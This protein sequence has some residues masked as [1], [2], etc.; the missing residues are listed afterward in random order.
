ML[1]A[2]FPPEF[3]AVIFSLFPIILPVKFDPPA[4]MV[5]EGIFKFRATVYCP[6]PPKVPGRTAEIKVP[7]GIFVPE[8]ICPNTIL[9]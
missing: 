8:I 1:A 9:P 7:A 5:W 2:G 4:I 3:I 6:T